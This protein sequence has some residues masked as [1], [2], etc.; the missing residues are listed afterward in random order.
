MPPNRIH[1][2]L[3]D[4]FKLIN[5][6]EEKQKSVSE[7]SEIFRCGKTLIYKCI[8]SKH[9]IK[10]KFLASNKSKLSSLKERHPENEVLNKVVYKWFCLARSKNFPLFGTIIQAEALNVAK[11]LKLNNFK[12]SNGWLRCLK[13]KCNFF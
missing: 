2:N 6:Y 1:L 7:L 10:R 5:L 4:K 11:T 13:K 8:S 9:E 3:K 12:A